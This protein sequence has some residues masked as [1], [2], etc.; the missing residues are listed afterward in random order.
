MSIDTIKPPNV[1]S[2]FQEQADKIIADFNGKPAGDGYLIQC[3]CD[4]HEDQNPSCKLTVTETGVVVHCYRCDATGEHRAYQALVAKRYLPPKYTPMWQQL[5][6]GARSPKLFANIYFESRGL[7]FREVPSLRESSNLKIHDLDQE[8]DGLLWSID[9]ATNTQR[10]IHRFFLNDEYDG[11]AEIENPKRILGDSKGCHICI[12]NGSS[13]TLHIAEGPINAH[14]VHQ[15]LP[16]SCANDTVWSAIR[17]SNFAELQVPEHFKIVHLW[18]DRDLDGIGERCARR[19]AVRLLGDGRTVFLHLP[20]PQGRAVD[21]NDVLDE[22]ADA[23]ANDGIFAL[24]PWERDGAFIPEPYILR[25][26]GVYRKVR[27][28]K[29]DETEEYEHQI[30]RLPVYVLRCERDVHT[31]FERVTI[32]WLLR[33]SGTY[34][35]L[36]VARGAIMTTGKLVEEVICKTSIEVRQKDFQEFCNYLQDCAYRI[37]EAFQQT[38]STTCWIQHNDKY[39]FVPYDDTIKLIEPGGPLTAI[40]QAYTQKGDFDTWYKAILEPMRVCP[41]FLTAFAFAYVSPLL[42]HLVGVPPFV[43][44]IASQSG[45]GKTRSSHMILSSFYQSI[46]EGTAPLVCQMNS[47]S[48][49]GIMQLLNFNQDL[50]L[51]FDDAQSESD[52]KVTKLVYTVG[53]AASATKCNPDGTLR[54]TTKVR[55]VVFITSEVDLATKFSY[56]GGNARIVTIAD[57]P[58]E[59]FTDTEQLKD[60]LKNVPL[61][62]ESNFGHLGRMYVQKIADILNNGQL[63]EL[64]ESFEKGRQALLQRANGGERMLIDRQWPYY[65]AALTACSIFYKHQLLP[66]DFVDAIG[67]AIFDHWQKALIMKSA[68]LLPERALQEL[69][70]YVTAHRE[71]FVTNGI[72]H[73]HHGEFQ[74]SGN[75]AILFRSLTKILGDGYDTQNIVSQWKSRGWLI[76]PPSMTKRTSLGLAIIN[77]QKV[78]CVVIKKEIFEQPITDLVQE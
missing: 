23:Y 28:S 77:G 74:K 47:A 66:K 31:K 73:E 67:N 54:E 46:P 32:K 48:L 14:S 21:F 8:F 1:T 29:K 72:S 4:D 62:L 30:C 10:G 45:T 35:E 64:R 7:D 6:N 58:F 69:R 5:W 22:I 52:E 51:C 11:Y 2:T 41:S 19:L 25:E 71:Q 3:P 40:S 57:P 33:E 42:P 75:L 24:T 26:D 9:D 78:S 65:A 61:V 18:A 17:V 70:D 27:K 36:T 49:P 38:A 60:V 37:R 13:E 34:S 50:P 53:N 12:H 59:G 16:A 39:A 15:K 20:R 76:Q 56:D 68:A 43:V 63:A 55:S 44:N